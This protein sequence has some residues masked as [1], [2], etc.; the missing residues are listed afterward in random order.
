MLLDTGPTFSTI[1]ANV[2]VYA[3]EV[4]A[5]VDS[6]VYAVLGLVELERVITEVREAYGNTALRLAG[7]VVT[8]AVRSNVCRDVEAELRNR[9][10]GLVYKAVIPLSSKVDEAH[11]HGKTV[12]DFA[13]KSAPA[14][15]YAQLVQEIDRGREKDRG[16]GK[17]VGRAGK[18]DAA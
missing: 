14:L 7:L 2:L 1:L 3:S 4:I 10:G 11:T 5:P 9:F 6:G 15:A 12:T 13:P 16:R 8:K 18:V 17:A